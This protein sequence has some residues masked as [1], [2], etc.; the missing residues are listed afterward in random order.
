MWGEDA[1]CVSMSDS[2]HDDGW[3]CGVRQCYIVNCNAYSVHTQ[4]HHT[5]YTSN[6]CTTPPHVSDQHT[7]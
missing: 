5:T 7:H 6:T 1:M 4:P 3:Q 2:S